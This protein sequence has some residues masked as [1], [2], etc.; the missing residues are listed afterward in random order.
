MTGDVRTLHGLLEASARGRPNALCL[1]YGSHK[2]YTYKDIQEAMEQC[3]RS[4]VL[5]KMPVV[6]LVADRSYGLVVGLLGILRAGKA[7]CPIEPDFPSS[8]AAIMFETAG[9]KDV[10]V[11]AGQAPDVLSD[12][13]D[14]NILSVHENGR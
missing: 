5:L 4:V 8:R 14:L 13:N 9:I 2:G 12:F 11:P 7:Y 1:K 10:L 6:A 3:A